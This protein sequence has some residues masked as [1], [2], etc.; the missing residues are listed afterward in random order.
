LAK[1]VIFRALAKSTKRDLGDWASRYA[2]EIIL[3][4]FILIYW[5]ASMAGNLNIGIR[6]ILPT[7]PFAYILLAVCLSAWVRGNQKGSSP[8]HLK[9]LLV[10]W[11]TRW[12]KVSVLGVLLAWYVFSSLSAYP[13]SLA[14]FNELAGGPSGGYRF[15]TDSNLDWGQ[16]LRA[17]ADFV[18]ENNISALRLDY[19]GTANSGYFLGDAYI[20]FGNTPPERHGWIAVS[21]TKMQEGRAT[22]TKGY[23]DRPTD[24]YRWLDAYEPRA[25]INHTIFVY[26][27]P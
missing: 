2:T 27:I 24:Y 25:I 3:F 4:V 6:H 11:Y 14:Y 16:D 7:M 10:L 13:H 23:A 20:P 19:F 5:I 26:Y 18:E 15:V 9:E 22:A 12:L 21:A 17:L 1:I 8:M